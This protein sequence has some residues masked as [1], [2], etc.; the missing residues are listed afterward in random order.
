MAKQTLSDRQRLEQCLSGARPDRTPVALW[1]HFPVDDQNPHTLAAAVAHFQKDYDFD[2][3]KVTPASSYCIKDWGVEDE[4]KGNPE[5]T[6]EYT[7]HT[8]RRP[9]DWGNLPVLEP[10]RGHLA[11]QLTCLKQ[12]SAEFGQETPILE[13]IFSPL[14]QAKNLIGRE[15][16]LVHLR[17]YPDAV[18]AG[19][20]KI[21]EGIL[22]YVESASQA[23]IAGIFYAVQHAQYGL[24]STE[25]Y[26]RFGKPYDLKILEA[27]QGLWLNLLHLHG[28]DVMFDLLK[29][30][31]VA[32]VNWHDQQTPPSLA[33][34]QKAFKGV[35]CGGLRQ[36]ETMVLGS[37][38]NV[39][40]E[41]R[42]AIAAT[43]GQRF[44]LGTGCVV[45]ITAPHGNIAT[46]RRCVEEIP[47]S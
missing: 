36:W 33:E 32:I 8:I 30:Y 21:T 6:R 14:A 31:P 3:I 11:E 2:L 38:E 47:L 18:H 29:D 16:L 10:S 42:A 26:E 7:V 24:L 28:N 13:T 17:K 23:G 9:E 39:H 45:P 1:R 37:N 12:L 40:A 19:L 41:A 46:V 25:E 35:V 44:I 5:G 4:W 15:D 22:R 43:Q 20:Q 27:A 34:G